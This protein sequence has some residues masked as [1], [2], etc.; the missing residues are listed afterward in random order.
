MKINASI[1]T[2]IKYGINKDLLFSASQILDFVN[3]AAPHLKTL[4]SLPKKL[5]VVI[6]PIRAG[7]VTKIHGRY[8]P[9]SKKIEINPRYGF[10]TAITTFMHELVHAEQFH[11]GALQFDYCKR[12][13]IWKGVLTDNVKANKDFEKYLNLPWEQEAFARQNELAVA[14]CNLTKINPPKF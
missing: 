12:E 4:F 11:L 10:S 3:K 7:K 5:D 6:R 13:F 14:I 2:S 9:D 1:A 8:I